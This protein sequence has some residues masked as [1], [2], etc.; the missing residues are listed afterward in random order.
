MPA[1]VLKLTFQTFFVHTMR[2]FFAWYAKLREFRML[3]LVHGVPVPFG[4]DHVMRH[5]VQGLGI[6]RFAFHRGT[7]RDV[8]HGASHCAYTYGSTAMVRYLCV[9]RDI[10]HALPPCTVGVFFPLRQAAL[11]LTGC[12][13]LQTMFR[14]EV[15]FK[16]KVH[17]MWYMAR[18]P[19]VEC[20][21]VVSRKKHWF[22]SQHINPTVRAVVNCFM[23][24]LM[25]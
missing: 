1:N 15:S 19:N 25:P 23:R 11:I 24:S 10:S 3:V 9:A 2:T 17:K 8:L 20:F 21:C 5:N 22:F 14:N 16:R 7:S 6:I 18:F 13:Q 4:W 12:I